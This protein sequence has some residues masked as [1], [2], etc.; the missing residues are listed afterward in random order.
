MQFYVDV[1]VPHTLLSYFNLAF[2]TQFWIY[3]PSRLHLLSQLT[4]HSTLSRV[5]C[6]S[7]SIPAQNLFISLLSFSFLIFKVD[8]QPFVMRALSS[9][10]KSFPTFHGNTT[11]LSQAG[12]G[13]LTMPMKRSR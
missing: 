12:G 13:G 10:A 3:E 1:E 7:F 4:V 2:V 8:I 11:T 9:S 6:V 5:S